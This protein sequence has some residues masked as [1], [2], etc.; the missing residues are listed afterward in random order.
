[1]RILAASIALG[2]LLLIGALPTTG[3]ANP[4][5]GTGGSIRLAAVSDTTADRDTY[6]QRA[7]NEM[8]EWQRKLHDFSERTQAKA[9]GAQAKATSDLNEAWTETKDASGRLETASKADWESTK[10]SFQSATHK[11]A[12]AWHKVDSDKK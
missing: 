10:S 4:A 11:L 9:P 7:R 1:M 8:K 12:V 2:S 3:R 5:H 6:T